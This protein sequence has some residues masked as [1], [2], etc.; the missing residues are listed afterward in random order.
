MEKILVATD[1]SV[2]R[3]SL[4]SYIEDLG[5]AGIKEVVL[6]NVVDDNE[7]TGQIKEEAMSQLSLLG[8]TLEEKGFKTSVCLRW[9]KPAQEI[10]EVAIME[11]V[12]FILVSSKGKQYLKRTL[13]GSTSIEL[14]EIASCPVLI[15][16]GEIEASS[17]EQSVHFRKILV[18]TDFSLASLEALDVIKILREYIGEVVF[19]HV[20]EDKR[21]DEKGLKHIK[22]NLDELVEEMQGFGINAS[23]FIKQGTPSKE[24]IKLSKKVLA[25]MIILPKVGGSVVKN[26][27]LGSTAQAVAI[28]VDIP[29]MMVPAD[30][31]R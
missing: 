20:V 8:E 15:E 30:L 13:W 26:I 14:V 31:G 29:V 4:F 27:L 21:V 9:G 5:K 28:G 10:S 19:V 6:A 25:S 22:Y 18:P 3:E 16:R 2:A 17:D 11:N 12:D 1:F 7:Q 23:S 24:I